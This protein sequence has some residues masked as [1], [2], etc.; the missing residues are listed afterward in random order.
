[1]KKIH[2]RMML[3]VSIALSGLSI[4]SLPVYAQDMAS[5]PNSLVVDDTGKVGIGTPTPE[6]AVDVLR[7]NAAARFQLTSITDVE[8]E[9]AQFIQR[10]A[11]SGPGA[12]QTNDQIGIFS[13]RGWNGTAYTGSKALISAKAEENWTTTANGTKIVFATTPNGGTTVRAVM[14][15]TQDGKVKIN[16]TELIVPD[17]V[18]EPDYKLMPLEELQAYLN[19]EKRLPKLSSAG[20]VN[21]E[22]LDLG[23]T[24]MALLEKVEELTLYT[25]QQHG[26]LKDQREQIFEQKAM[27][28]KLR[29]D[30]EAR[31]MALET[32]VKEKPAVVKN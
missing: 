5:P 7:S 14:I 18:F 15:I 10:R 32:L 20:E 2:K 30:Y 28:A 1:M 4:A 17:Y 29:K 9:G 13:F 25:L 24:Q 12:V 11:R 21:A 26:Q 23:G 27:I 8:N 22:G 6:Q 19:K 16:G 31:L 3:G